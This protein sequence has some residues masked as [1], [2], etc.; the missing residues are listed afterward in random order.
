MPVL[1]L[2]DGTA[3]RTLAGFLVGFVLT[4]AS[5]PSLFVAFGRA[6]CGDRE[7]ADRIMERS[8]IWR[9]LD[10]VEQR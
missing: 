10:W 2:G 6:M 4:L 7:G 1:R 9:Y 8:P 5:L 3:V